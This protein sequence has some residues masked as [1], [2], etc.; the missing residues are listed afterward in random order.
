MAPRKWIF[1]LIGESAM[2]D[3]PNELRS[4]SD[5]L[6]LGLITDQVRNMVTDLKRKTGRT[7]K[8]A[9][10]KNE[11]LYDGEKMVIELFDTLRE[12]VDHAQQ[13]ML[14]EVR[15][16]NKANKSSED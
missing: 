16:K 3:N 5:L 2:D 13:Q 4:F 10:G 14:E 11:S 15:S 7:V 9:M 8:A 6:L 1:V 12:A